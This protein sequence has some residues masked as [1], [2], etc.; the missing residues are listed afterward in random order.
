MKSKALSLRALLRSVKP[1]TRLLLRVGLLLLLAVYCAATVLYAAAHS[2]G[3]YQLL[4]LAAQRL[5][6]GV[7]TGFGVLGLGFLLLEC[8]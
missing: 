7:K 2:G 5:C 8:K 3:E 6:A 4:L 1:E